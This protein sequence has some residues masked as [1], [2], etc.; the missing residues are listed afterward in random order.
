M[1]DP[2]PMWIDDDCLTFVTV[3][4]RPNLY[5]TS[6]PWCE[7]EQQFCNDRAAIRV[8]QYYH[9]EYH[10]DHIV[11]LHCPT[12]DMEKQPSEDE[13]WGTISEVPITHIPVKDCTAG[14]PEVW[15]RLL[16]MPLHAPTLVHC[17]AGC[18]RTA[19][20][21]LMHAFDALITSHPEEFVRITL[22]FFGFSDYAVMR[23]NFI[24][25]T[26][27][28]IG[29]VQD[30]H[31]VTRARINHFNMTI[32]YHE[33]FGRRLTFQGELMAQRFTLLSR[34]LCR[35]YGLRSHFVFD[36]RQTCEEAEAPDQLP[37]AHAHVEAA[38]VPSTS[39]F[40][41]SILGQSAGSVRRKRRSKRK[42]RKRRG[43][44]RMREDPTLLNLDVTKYRADECP[45]HITLRM[46]QLSFDVPEMRR[47]VK[48]MH[49][50]DARDYM[51]NTWHSLMMNRINIDKEI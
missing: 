12:R 30:D 9:D 50:D 33:M 41:P 14:S 11:S 49:E 39:S 38:S 7:V 17:Y 45:N 4:G 47:L 46:L 48:S 2:G 1:E 18:G 31:P 40:G 21:L 43:G 37:D 13:L 29:L 5:G 22:P 6:V 26:K 35:K 27:R 23:D 25:F 44:S 34:A 8:L 51:W 42:T 20:V 19:W 32:L 3:R 15:D 24:L 10:V 28:Y 36:M 16:S